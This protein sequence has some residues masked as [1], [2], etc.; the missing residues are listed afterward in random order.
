VHCRYEEHEL[1]TAFN[2]MLKAGLTI[3]ARS[4]NEHR[5]RRAARLLGELRT[6]GRARP[7]DWH[8][9]VDRR[10]RVYEPSI[11]LARML[12]EG[13]AMSLDVGELSVRC[14]L[15][16]SAEVFE[17]GIRAHIERH[18]GVD[19]HVSKRSFLSSTGGIRFSPDLVI[20]GTGERVVL[21]VKYRA[22]GPDWDS[23][24]RNQVVAF[25]AAA[26]ARRAAV[27]GIEQVAGRC[28]RPFTIGELT[29]RPIRWQATAAH[30]RPQMLEDVAELVAVSSVI[31]RSE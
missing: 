24:S 27:I 30:P 17:N 3:A 16:R 28:P 18:L 25:A 23:G 15:V 31:A 22:F 9:A 11:T 19:A 21:D 5:A 14:F 12:V 29:V 7:T 13:T 2:R 6:V 10:T 8:D 4:T 20:D 26:K 1:D